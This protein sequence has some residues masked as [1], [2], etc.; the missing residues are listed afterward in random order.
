[1][2]DWMNEAAGTAHSG[3]GAPLRAAEPSAVSAAV[4]ASLSAVIALIYP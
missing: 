1:M 2:D 4:R 3:M